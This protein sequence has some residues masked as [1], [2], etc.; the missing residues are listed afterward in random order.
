MSVRSFGRYRILGILKDGGMGRLSLA[1]M[2]G[3]QDFRR[4][5]VLKQILPHLAESDSVLKM[6]MNE[7]RLAAR[8]DHP[9]IIHIFELGQHKKQYFMSM[10]YLPG[11]DLSRVVK[12]CWKKKKKLPVP[13]ALTVARNVAEALHHAHEMVNDDGRPAGLVHRDVSPSNVVMTYYGATKLLDFGVAKATA[14]QGANQT[15]VGTFKGKYGY[16]SPEQVR[17]ESID[18]RSDIFALGTVMWEML[19]LRRLFRRQSDAATIRAVEEA[20]VPSLCQLHPEIPEVLDRIVA[21]ALAREKEDR[22]QSAGEMADALE[23]AIFQVGEPA[24]SR[25]VAQWLTQLF[26]PEMADLKQSLAQGRGIN[27]S[28]RGPALAPHH[29]EMLGIKP[30]PEE[31]DDAAEPATDEARLTR[32]PA[33]T[34]RKQGQGSPPLPATS[35]VPRLSNRPAS[36]ALAGPATP[37]HSSP[38]QPASAPRSG[39]LRTTWSVDDPFS[40]LGLTSSSVS[41]SPAQARA[42]SMVA[43]RSSHRGPITHT[44]S[45]T[46]PRRAGRRPLWA[47]VIA[48]MV[49][50]AV[51]AVLRWSDAG[52]APDPGTASRLRVASHPPGATVFID[53]KRQ[54]RSTPVELTDLMRGE[55]VRIRLEK[56]GYASEV[57]DVELDSRR[58]EKTVDLRILGLIEFEALPEGAEVWIDAV[59]VDDPSVPSEVA[60]G[61]HQLRIRYA[62]GG[63]ERRKLIVRPGFQTVTVGN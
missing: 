60:I 47:G 50:V 45:S 1:V 51:F 27:L 17:G 41:E 62:S 28:G 30:L 10:E 21:R 6:F 56:E 35:D 23:K 26:G 24:S 48:G 15:Q 61:V 53:G 32:E 49:P 2:T 3:V 9:S 57:V 38:I 16:A 42:G 52:S 55:R 58:V 59:R 29:V 19:A 31:T 25:F 18:A 5:V 7:A 43:E 22:F 8:L 44:G 33:S 40:N 37:R 46:R 11:E 12:K 34:G 54:D 63:E 36:S 4:I 13:V 39:Q 20:A 14:L